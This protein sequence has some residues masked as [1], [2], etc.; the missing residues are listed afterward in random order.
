MKLLS[1]LSSVTDGENERNWIPSESNDYRGIKKKK[2]EYDL[3]M[4][5]IFFSVWEGDKTKI[6][7]PIEG[8]QHIDLSYL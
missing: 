5:T 6:K 7:W 1:L 8:K 3:N 2:K 4:M